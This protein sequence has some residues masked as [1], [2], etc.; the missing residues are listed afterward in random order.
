MSSEGEKATGLVPSPS[1]TLSR[2]GSKSLVQRGMQDWLAAREDAERWCDLGFSYECGRG[3]PKDEKQAAFC[4]RKAAD[5]GHADAQF[6]LAVMYQEGRGVTHDP[7][8]VVFWF[9]KSAAQGDEGA[10]IMLG[11]DL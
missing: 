3:V 4:Y 2:A 9:H 11:R 1:S 5:Q 10:Q 7:A 8:Q 6:M